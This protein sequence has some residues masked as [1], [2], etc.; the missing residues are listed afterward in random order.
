ME[1]ANASLSSDIY[2]R[3]QPLG[4]AAIKRSCPHPIDLCGA[5]RQLAYVTFLR[6]S[7]APMGEFREIFPLVYPHRGFTSSRIA[8]I[9]L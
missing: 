6:F 4:T 7:S 8:R 2:C 9:I 1:C 3:E 5:G